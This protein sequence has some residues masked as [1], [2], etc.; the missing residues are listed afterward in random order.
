VKQLEIEKIIEASGDSLAFSTHRAAFAAKNEVWLEL[1]DKEV[2]KLEN[3][4]INIERLMELGGQNRVESQKALER[5]VRDGQL[6]RVGGIH[7]YRKTIQ[8][9]VNIIHKYYQTH[10]TMSVGELRDLLQTS[11]KTA[12]P[13]MEYLDSN[14]YTFRK[15]DVRIAGP[16]LK[17]E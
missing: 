17:P 15:G 2:E 6:V 7:V 8:Y 11:R 16:N 4:E 9:I 12:V 1:L 3:L 14:K 13:L 5:L 10:E